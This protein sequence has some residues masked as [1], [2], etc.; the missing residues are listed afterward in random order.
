ML[1]HL[2]EQ[3]RLLLRLCRRDGACVGAA[4]EVGGMGMCIGMRKR[5]TDRHEG[6]R[7][8]RILAALIAS[9]LLSLYHC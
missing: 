5:E 3:I 9:L 7:V 8:E 1:C 4:D 6:E 2:H